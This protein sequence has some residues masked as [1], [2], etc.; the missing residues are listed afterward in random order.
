MER[1]KQGLLHLFE[2]LKVWRRGDERA[3]HKPLLLLL[4]LSRVAGRQPR[5]TPF[6]ELEGPL[7]RLLR[8]Y[9]PPRKSNHPEY[10]FWRLQ[11]DGLWEVVSTAPL[12]RRVSNTDPPRSELRSKNAVGGFTQDVYDQLRR[13][14]NLVIRIARRLL[15]T[16]F[17]DSLHEDLL[18]E[19]GLP[20]SAAVRTRDPRFRS[21]VIRA[22]EHRCA[23]CGFDLKVGDADFALEAAHIKWHQAGGP[24]EVTNGIA[25]C[26]VHHK[27]LDRGVIGLTT[28][29]TIIISADLHGL[30]GAKEWFETF[31][32]RV[33]RAPTRS[34]WRP[35]ESYLNWHYEQVFRRPPKE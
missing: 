13:S 34:E 7:T 24:D 25:L 16:N 3:P 18:T 20:T 32:G 31:K 30:C 17:P 35:K 19:V 21:E 5:L 14:P 23:V 28:E 27:A 12:A 29:M 2:E 6:S 15:E 4:A 26:V 10:P 33:I 9:G 22:Y 11:Q 1:K 8:D